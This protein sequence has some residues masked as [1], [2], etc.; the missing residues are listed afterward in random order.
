MRA[1]D[2][3]DRFRKIVAHDSLDTG[4]R[5]LGIAAEIPTVGIFFATTPFLYW[6]RIPIHDNVFNADGSP[7]AVDAVYAAARAMLAR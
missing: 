3:R 1:L 5:N 6:P 4:I 2:Q 7:P